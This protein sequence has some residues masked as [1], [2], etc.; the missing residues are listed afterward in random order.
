MRFP[1]SNKLHRALAVGILI[2]F[3]SGIGLAVA[4]QDDGNDSLA[5][6]P[7]ALGPVSTTVPLATV[8]PPPD[9]PTPGGTTGPAPGPGTT[10]SPDLDSLADTGAD[11]SLQWVGYALLLAPLGLCRLLA[12]S[13]PEVQ[14]PGDE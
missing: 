4:R 11:G 1:L 13:R 12:C 9:S 10:T 2:V 3:L 7:T 14:R 5:G 6:N 8:P